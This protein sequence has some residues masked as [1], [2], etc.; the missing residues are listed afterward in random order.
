MMATK[1][2]VTSISITSERH[3]PPGLAI[4]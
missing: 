3:S 1:M 4:G 2:A